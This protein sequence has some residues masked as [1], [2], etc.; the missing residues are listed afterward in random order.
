MQHSIKK[1]GF[2]F[3]VYLTLCS[4]FS[5]ITDDFE[6]KKN[7]A[8]S[9]ETL[10]KGINLSLFPSVKINSEIPIVAWLGVP[11]SHT[12]IERFQ[13]MKK[14]G[15]NINYSKYS[16]ADSLQ[17]ALDIANKVDMKLM[18]YCPELY[19]NTE[20]TV[21]RF[22]DHPANGGYF[23]L[24][25]PLSSEFGR[26]K[27]LEQKIEAIDS[28]RF[29]YINLLPNVAIPELY[30][31]TD[32]RNYVNTFLSQIPVKI[33]SF[34]HYPI[35]H[36]G[37]RVNW[38]QNLE[39]ISSEAKNADIPFWAFA[40]TTAHGPYPIPDLSQL[41]LQVYSNLAYGA[42]GIQYFTYWTNRSAKWN[43]HSGP[44]EIDG[45]KTV[46]YDYLQ[47]INKEIQNFSS[48][49]LTSKISKVS[50]Y[51]VIPLGTMEFTNPPYFINSI[52]INNGNA[53]LSEMENNQNSFFMIQNTTLDK[54][55]GVDIKTDSHTKIILK[56]GSVIPASYI[57]EE[58]KLTPGDMVIFM[59]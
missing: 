55:I 46:V 35:M 7:N 11:Q 40:L 51:G 50:H 36:G 37:I 3:I 15:I 47:Q 42:K 53:L 12:N 10:T 59:R 2:Y 31:P 16:N 21:L 26:L 33:L 54:E 24:D 27:E 45:S 9:I 13:E 43:F 5:D 30:S 32:Y 19:N 48:I 44:I 57:K 28:S 25:E 4:C 1:S 23:M 39:I 38:Y 52:K 56:N 49:F 41:R 8:K 6:V 17:K 22:K 20:A 34:D 58:F 29:C 18:I 14:A